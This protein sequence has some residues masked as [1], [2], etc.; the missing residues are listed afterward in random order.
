MCCSVSVNDS[1]K[2]LILSAYM[3]TIRSYIAN[4]YQKIPNL[5]V[6][7]VYAGCGGELTGY[8]RGWVCHCEVEYVV[9]FRDLLFIY[10]YLLLVLDVHIQRLPAVHMRTFLAFFLSNAWFLFPVHTRGCFAIYAL[11]MLIWDFVNI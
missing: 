3:R 4:Q 8:I 11:R 9:G 10:E 7:T 1:T 2:I 6:C 5:V